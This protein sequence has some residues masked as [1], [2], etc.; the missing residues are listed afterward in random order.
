M[1]NKTI[2]TVYKSRLILAKE[3]AKANNIR[4]NLTFNLTDKI[5]DSFVEKTKELIQKSL[6]NTM[7]L[8]IPG[9]WGDR[10]IDISANIYIFLKNSGIACEIVFGDIEILGEKKYGTEIKSLMLEHN[11]N[12]KNGDQIIHTWITLGDDVIIDGAIYDMT[13][14]D[15]NWPLNWNNRIIVSRVNDLNLSKKIEYIPMFIGAGFLS[16]TNVFP[17]SIFFDN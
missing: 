15:L 1:Q 10:C 13:T 5:T 17:S 7:S 14:S 2:S 12:K 3:C 9:Y 6:T 4:H 8:G 11:K 16:T